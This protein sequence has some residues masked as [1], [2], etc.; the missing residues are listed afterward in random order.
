MARRKIGD[1]S[2]P[3]TTVQ[4]PTRSPS[5]PVQANAPAEPVSDT[6]GTAAVEAP[7]EAPAP[8]PPNGKRKPDQTYKVY[9]DR[10]TVLEVGIW[11]NEVRYDDK[12]SVQHTIQISRS[13]KNGEGKWVSSTT[14]RTHDLP[15][16][17]VLL[18]LAHGWCVE[19]RTEDGSIPF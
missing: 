2:A 13:F 12:V 5:E 16:V 19:R 15:H 10:T 4:E 7:K 11:E 6:N 3:A 17:R 18:D 9:S 14:Y 1:V 8:A